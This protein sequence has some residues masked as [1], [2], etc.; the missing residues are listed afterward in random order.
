MFKLSWVP[1]YST[2]QVKWL[3]VLSKNVSCSCNVALYIPNLVCL[4]TFVSQKY[5][6]LRFYQYAFFTVWGCSPISI[7]LLFFH[8]AF[9]QIPKVLNFLIYLIYLITYMPNFLCVSI[10]ISYIFLALIYH[11][12]SDLCFPCQIL[13][14]IR[15]LLSFAEI[16]ISSAYARIC[17]WLFIIYFPN[18]VASITAFNTML[19]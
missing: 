14:C 11:Y 2:T 3:I 6:N 16:T 13:H 15:L 12:S 19:K 10:R 7:L 1:V 9:S 18:F 5:Q 4:L 8:S 17:V